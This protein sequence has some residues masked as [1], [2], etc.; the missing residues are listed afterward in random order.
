MDK[1]EEP[2]PRLLSRLETMLTLLDRLDRRRA[3]PAARAEVEAAVTRL[4]R[5][6]LYRCLFPEAAP[7]LRPAEATLRDAGVELC[8]G[9]AE[10]EEATR[11]G[12]DDGAE[13]DPED[14]SFAARFGLRVADLRVTEAHLAPACATPATRRAAFALLARLAARRVT[15]EDFAAAAAAARDAARKLSTSA[16]LRAFLSSSARSAAS[17]M[18]RA[19]S[20]R[21]SATARASARALV[22]AVTAAMSPRETAGAPRLVFSS[23]VVLTAEMDARRPRRAS[24]PGSEP[25]SRLS[26]SVSLASARKSPRNLGGG[27]GK[28]CARRE[29]VDQLGFRPASSSRGIG[30]GAESKAFVSVGERGARGGACASRD[31]FEFRRAKSRAWTLRP[32]RGAFASHRRER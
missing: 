25:A 7:L 19:A 20:A 14:A 31:M 28:R 12:S 16:R 13:D 8:G 27:G 30:L 23:S 5:T 32:V 22:L 29:T 18:R 26:S 10:E 2:D 4:A 6:L 1:E 21:A 9:A 24:S 3:A 17:V 11:E 15:S